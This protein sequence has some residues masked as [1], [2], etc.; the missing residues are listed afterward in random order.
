GTLT[1]T[2]T[3]TFTTAY[4]ITFQTEVTDPEIFLGNYKSGD[5]AGDDP[6]YYNTATLTGT[7]SAEGLPFTADSTSKQ[8]VTSNVV[9]KRGQGYDHASRI[10]TWQV[11]INENGSE[12]KNAQLTDAIP[13]GQE[14]VPDSFEVGG[15]QIDDDMVYT[16]ATAEQTDRTG[17]LE[18][19][20]GGVITSKQTVTFQTTLTDLSI[21]EEN[22]TTD[23][24]KVK[25][26]ANLTHIFAGNEVSVDSK[27]EQGIDNTLIGKEGVR[28]KGKSYIDWTVT[29][30]SN[31]IPL[32]EVVLTDQLQDYL[33]L[34]TLSVKLYRQTLAVNGTLTPNILHPIPLDG[35]NIDYDSTTNL[36]TFTMPDTD[37]DPLE[38]AYQLLFRTY[39]V[40]PEGFSGNVTFRNSITMNGTGFSEDMDS[41]E[42][43]FAVADMGGS[44]QGELGSIT[45]IKVNKDR[46]QDTL[47]GAVFTLHDRFGNQ[48]AEATTDGDGQVVFERLHFDVNYTIVEAAEPEGFYADVLSHLFSI[49]GKTKEISVDG[50]GLGQI[51]AYIWENIKIPT[52]PDEIVLRA[53]KLFDGKAPEGSDFTFLLKDAMGETIQTIANNGGEVVF[54]AL[55]LPGDYP[56]TYIYTITE[57]AGS[58]VKLRYDSAIYLV[59]INIDKNP[60][61]P[62]NYIIDISY[63]KTTMPIAASRPS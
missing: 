32:S 8:A 15:I 35:D 43:S 26:T 46:P 11:V 29:I 5:K 55:S 30:N 60:E 61:K 47:A 57:E 51:A 28:P 56:A 23:T 63:E 59:T 1:Y 34:D 39:I 41:G 17:T 14:Y 33:V 40:L 62:Y 31:E 18:Y 4:T 3:G 20:F 48:I 7:K 58:D 45:I 49:D 16:A 24:I 6:Y 25:N 52:E 53:S 50:V 9:T 36:F 27:G 38:G 37:E 19:S 13:L 54:D 44:A 2:K 10:I 42:I 22:G 21:F 12:L